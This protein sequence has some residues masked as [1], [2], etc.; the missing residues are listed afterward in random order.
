LY[1]GR[2]WRRR[3]TIRGCIAD[4]A[5]A[6]AYAG[7]E[8]VIVVAEQ[9]RRHRRRDR[10]PEPARSTAIPRDGFAIRRTASFGVAVY[11]HDAVAMDQLLAIA[12]HALCT[13]KA[14]GETSSCADS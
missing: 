7:D 1:Q 6:V 9:E 11:P 5:F 14:R 2:A 4:P 3:C 8:F 10:D 13:A 12:D